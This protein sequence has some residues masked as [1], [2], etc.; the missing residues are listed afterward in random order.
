MQL[1]RLS[2]NAAGNIRDLW[3][4]DVAGTVPRELYVALAQANQAGTAGQWL[5]RQQALETTTRSG[6]DFSRN[7]LWVEAVSRYRR[8]PMPRACFARIE[9]VLL[10]DTARLS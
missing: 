1:L 10:D 5:L 4:G 8:R 7:L 6:F 3:P 9:G 2:Y